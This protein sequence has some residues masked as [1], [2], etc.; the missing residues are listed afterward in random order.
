MNKKI[1][2]DVE[3]VFYENPN[4]YQLNKLNKNVKDFRNFIKNSKFYKYFYAFQDVV[5]LRKFCKFWD[6]HDYKDEFLFYN[7]SRT[8]V[9]FVPVE[10][11]LNEWDFA[12]III[13]KA[14]AWG[15]EKLSVKFE[16]NYLC[17]STYYENICLRLDE[18]DL[19]TL[20]LHQKIKTAV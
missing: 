15:I 7:D 20:D 18:A 1:S 9:I 16:S 10:Y 19:L 11:L 4:S 12:N 8:S 13:E 6:T 5:S 3:I 14:E 2:S 17:S